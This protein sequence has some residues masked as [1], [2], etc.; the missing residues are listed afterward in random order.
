MPQIGPD[1]VLTHYRIVE[2]LGEGGMGVVWKAFDIRLN[3]HVA[4]KVLRP[5][6]TG[7]SDRQRRFLREAR[8]A[9]S[10]THANIVTIHEV[11]EIDGTTFLCMELVEGRTLRAVI[12]GSHPLPISEVL[13]I[14]IEVA[15]GL[16]RAHRGGIVHRDLKPENVILGSDGR[17][18]ILD[19]GLAKLAELRNEAF[20]LGRSQLETRTAE[21]TGAEAIL[22]TVA[23]MSPEQ[24]RGDSVDPRSD[25]FSFGVMLYELATGRRPFD[26]PGQI[27]TL[28]AILHEPAPPASRHRADVPARLQEVLD[29]CLEKDPGSR[30]QSCD[31]LVV[32]LRRIRR[33]L[34]SG[35]ARTREAPRG[36]SGAERRASIAVLPFL[37]LSA[38]AAQSFFASGLHD[39]LLTQLA[40]VA[41]LKVISRTSVMG[42]RDTTKSLK[43]IGQELEVG[44]IVEGSVQVLGNR[45]RVNVQLIDAA[46][47]EHLWAESYDRTLE[48]AFAIQS[49]MA[50]RVVAA[51]GAALGAEERRAIAAAPT[52]NPEAYQLFLQAEAYRLRPGYLR[53][54]LETGQ[55]L[56]ERALALDPNFALAHAALSEIHGH[57]HWHR[58]DPSPGRVARQRE[59]AETAL[60]LAPDLPQSHVA[61]GR[62][63]YWCQSDYQGALE[64]F[65]IA[66]RRMPNDAELVLI[67]GAVHRRLGNWSAVRAAYD[68][69]TQL[70]PRS[71]DLHGDLGGNTFTFLRQYAEAVQAFDRSVALAGIH[72]FG[73]ERAEAWLLWKGDLTALQSLVDS[74]GPDVELGGG[75]TGRR[76]RAELLLMQRRSDELL[77]LVGEA[78][79]PVFEGQYFYTPLSMYVAWAHELEGRVAEARAAY[80]DALE[81][82]ESAAAELPHDWRIHHSRGLAL[83]GLERSGEALSEVQWLRETHVYRSD[84]LG[85]PEIA[86][87]CALILARSGESDAALNEVE[88]VLAG[89]AN[90][91]VHL[92][93]LDPRW[94]P[95]RQHPRFEALLTKYALPVDED[96][97]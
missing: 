13:R 22:G 54:N 51:V 85:G 29:K 69:A 80:R 90:L 11:D 52:D 66:L 45:L 36:A 55:E 44:N 57:L 86:T 23:Y 53:G 35:V 20:R 70:N 89:P 5:E 75:G 3:R 2:K 39:E 79:T 77:G 95:I 19:F 71:A 68:R 34:E 73:V 21:L 56:Y 8:A 27:A 6:L 60:R 46:T 50:Q 25:I 64:E 82:L 33:D 16:V 96:A 41:A 30:Y 91:S 74:V 94:D 18:K 83:A 81:I 28:A 65:E 59:A 97:A 24:A 1:T 78:I 26:G 10:V 84:A 87:C 32:D 63:L 38:D 40:K 88:R 67:I 42:Y 48:D 49:D 61:M 17:P 14:V 43:V 76:A 72:L 58:Y 62:V 31:D 47:D 93:R 4:L 37:N 92:L 7:E 15:E 9:A 12:T